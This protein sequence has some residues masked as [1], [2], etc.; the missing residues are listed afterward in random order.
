MST[1]THNIRTS[2]QP[3]VDP[4][5]KEQT[6]WA[7]Q[8]NVG[9]EV[10]ET[11]TTKLHRRVLLEDHLSGVTARDRKPITEAEVHETARKAALTFLRTGETAARR[12]ERKRYEEDWAGGYRPFGRAASDLI[13]EFYGGKPAPGRSFGSGD[14]TIPPVG[15]TEVVKEAERA[16][17]TVRDFA[18]RINDRTR[19]HVYIGYG[20]AAVSFILHAVNFI[21]P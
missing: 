13:A 2:V 14:D 4:F 19:T 3:T 1:K 9:A 16:A 12:A 21:N 10:V 7:W 17:S 6:G 8:A 20:F 15:R 11:G 5:S 18:L